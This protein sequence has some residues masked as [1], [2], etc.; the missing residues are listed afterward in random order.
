MKMTSRFVQLLVSLLAS[1]VSSY[2]VGSTMSTTVLRRT[3]PAT[4][5]WDPK[6]DDIFDKPLGYKNNMLTHSEEALP[7][8]VPPPPGYV[9]PDDGCDFIELDQYASAVFGRSV[10]KVDAYVC[11]DGEGEEAHPEWECNFVMHKGEVVQACIE[12]V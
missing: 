10:G 3:T 11:A 5:L 4:M 12:K 1:T 7:V 9:K 6:T 2:A 8:Y